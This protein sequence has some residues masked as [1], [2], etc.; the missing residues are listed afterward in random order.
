M[1]FK[2]YKTQSQNKLTEG[3]TAACNVLY[4]SI[5]SEE[6]TNIMSLFTI[7][8]ETYANWNLLY[9]DVSLIDSY[10][11]LVGHKL[12]YKIIP[13]W[14]SVKNMNDNGV[15]NYTKTTGKAGEGYAGFSLE[16]QEGQFQNNT[17]ESTMISN[18]GL[19]LFKYTMF[20]N[21]TLTDIYKRELWGILQHEFC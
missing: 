5:T 13:N 1:T 17:S 19:S 14:L 4:P 15:G 8:D 21:N 10:I 16:N 3:F 11:K 7:I 2:E 20:I 6:I 18:N 12:A 9:D